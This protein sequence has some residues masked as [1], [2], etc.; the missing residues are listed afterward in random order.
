LL[1]VLASN[2]LGTQRWG[3]CDGGHEVC[4]LS[5]APHDADAVY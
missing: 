3:F 4:V 1:G 2:E 5:E